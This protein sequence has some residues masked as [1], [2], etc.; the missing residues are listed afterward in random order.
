M[1]RTRA[2]LLTM[3]VAHAAIAAECARRLKDAMNDSFQAERTAETWRVSDVGNVVGST[4]HTR[5]DVVDR[6]AL[7]KWVAANYPTEVVQVVQVRNADWLTSVLD[8][9]A[10]VPPADADDTWKPKPGDTLPAQD[11]EGTVV[12]GVLWRKGGD[13]KTVSITPD[14]TL[15]RALA[16]AA[17][18]YLDS[19]R[20]APDLAAAILPAETTAGG[21][22]GAT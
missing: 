12:P 4:N 5:V 9:L 10:P 1:T 2:D 20:V 7:M 22:Q 6:D 15:K 13:F 3:M 11:G 18:D 21:G 16:A 19:G 17:V 8:Q 14:S